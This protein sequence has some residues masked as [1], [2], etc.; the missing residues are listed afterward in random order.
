MCYAK[1]IATTRGSLDEGAEPFCIEV[2]PLLNHQRGAAIACMVE[3]GLSLGGYRGAALARAYCQEAL[4]RPDRLLVL[5][6]TSGPQ[7]KGFLVVL[8]APWTFWRGFL[9]RHPLLALRLAAFSMVRAPLSS[10]VIPPSWHGDTPG[11]QRIMMIAVSPAYRQQGVGRDLYRGLFAHSGAE[12]DSLALVSRDNHASM[13]LHKST[14]WALEG[15]G[16]P[17]LATRLQ[18]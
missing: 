5:L 17:I 7:V 14:G 18:R 13:A 12:Q 3:C 15:E 1:G 2:A 4:S 9:L 11:P 16:N 6:A 10:D 8:R